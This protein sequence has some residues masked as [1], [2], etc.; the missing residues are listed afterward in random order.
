[1][2]HDIILVK[3]NRGLTKHIY[4]QEDKCLVVA[5]TFTM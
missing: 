2:I 5:N 4:M 3:V 1:M